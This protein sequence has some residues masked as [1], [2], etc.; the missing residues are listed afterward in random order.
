MDTITKMISDSYERRTRTGRPRSS[1]VIRLAPRLCIIALAIWPATSAGEP[2]SQ[3]DAVRLA[4]QRSV[5]FIEREGAEWITKKDCLSCH[6][7]SFMVWSLNAAKRN[8][9]PVDQAKLAAWTDW[10]TNWQHL[11]IAS[12]RET[13]VREDTLRDQPDTLAQLLLGRTAISSGAKPPQWCLDYASDLLKVQQPDGSWK[14]GGQLPSQKRPKRETQEVSTMWSLLALSDPNIPNDPAAST[15]LDKARAWLGDE[16]IGLSTEWWATRLM[17]ERKLGNAE[18][19]DRFRKGLLK[20]QRADGGWGWLCDDESDGLGT[21]IALFALAQDK[22]PATDPTVVK[23]RRFLLQKQNS[24]GSWPVRGTKMN[25]K[26]QIQPTAT[27]WGTC[28][29]VI[30]LCETLAPLDAK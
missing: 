25:K 23:A 4:I 19:A 9:I 17:F 8:G 30:G 6:H 2:N 16:T 22:L 12:V 13:A 15:A 7:T 11:V 1:S 20:R 24:D 27:F 26:D 3:R 10:A 18:K 5:P 14:S 29:A 28:W 21:G